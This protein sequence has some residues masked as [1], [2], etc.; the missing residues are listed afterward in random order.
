MMQQANVPLHHHVALR[1]ILMVR[2][3]IC[4]HRSCSVLGPV[5]RTRGAQRLGNEDGSAFFLVES[6]QF[7]DQLL[8]HGRQ[9]ERD[10][11]DD[12]WGWSEQPD[13][14]QEQDVFH[15]SQERQQQPL[16]PLPA[17]VQGPFD[18]F[19]FWDLDNKR[20]DGVAAEDVARHLRGTLAN[21]GAVR[22]IAAVANPATLAWR[23]EG[24]VR[25]GQLMRE[26][27]A[28]E[29]RT[30]TSLTGQQRCPMCGMTCKSIAHLQKHFRQLHE[31]EHKK[32]LAH[33]PGLRSY[34]ASGKQ[35][36][37]LQA[38]ARLQLSARPGEALSAEQQLR[39]AGVV[40]T[41]VR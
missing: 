32:Q 16:P 40:V 25:G 29:R 27:V 2:M 26:I 35:D 39:R 41:Q 38:R 14:P 10:E 19:V 22:S 18:I 34:V 30:K 7:L 6:D 28:T 4:S 12:G 9:G 20:S 36:R 24:V 8:Q 33:R 31:R 17:T 21:Y 1:R 13:V 23:P 15:H 37:F 5:A 3:L 11:D